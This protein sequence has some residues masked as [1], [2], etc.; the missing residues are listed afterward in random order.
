MNRSSENATGASSTAATSA[1][2]TSAAAPSPVGTGGGNHS[3]FLRMLF[4][5]SARPAA[6]GGGSASASHSSAATA[7]GGGGAAAGGGGGSTAATVAAAAG[8]GGGAA[9][10][11]RPGAVKRLKEIKMLRDAVK[12]HKALATHHISM[13][14]TLE[15]S[16]GSPEV[17]ESMRQTTRELVA[18][19]KTKQA[20]INILE[21]EVR[22]RTRP[23]RHRRSKKRATRRK[24]RN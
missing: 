18:K 14:K 11:N 13:I 24:H 4:P 22:T 7:A 9:P 1:A 17:I 2:A 12:T 3:G 6:G 20:Q 23:S 16:G 10:Q 21:D 5:K 15:T 8:G 19:I